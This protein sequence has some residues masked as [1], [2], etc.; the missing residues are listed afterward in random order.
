M[1][2]FNPFFNALF[3]EG[4]ST[5]E[6][7]LGMEL[8]QFKALDNKLFHDGFRLSFIYYGDS[9]YQAA[10]HESSEPQSWL[11]T[12]DF[13]ELGSHEKKNQK[14]G[15]RLKYLSAQE[16]HFIAIWHPGSGNQFWEVNIPF[17]EFKA[18]D[19]EFR[20]MGLVLMKLNNNTGN[21]TAFWQPGTQ[22][23]DWI[24]TDNPDQFDAFKENN[25]KRGF[26]GVSYGGDVFS[27]VFH[28]EK[29]DQRFVE[30]LREESFKKRAEELFK[31]NFH[32]VDMHITYG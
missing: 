16:D 18:K 25:K 12:E 22:K 29:G 1:A 13:D 26:L 23:Y 14:A 17:D 15:F 19:E 6:I 11:V 3:R 8:D 4:K 24:V 20:S 31:E 32:I 2:L 9:T 27:S 7:D 28:E 30:P 21:C 10:W 5:K